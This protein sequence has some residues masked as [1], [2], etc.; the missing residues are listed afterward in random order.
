MN[1]NFSNRTPIALEI[2]AKIDKSD[3]VKLKASAHLRKQ[4]QE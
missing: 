2:R 1:N 4:L 3:Y